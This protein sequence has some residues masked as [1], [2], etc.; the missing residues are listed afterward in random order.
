MLDFSGQ[1]LKKSLMRHRHSTDAHHVIITMFIPRTF[2]KPPVLRID[3]YLCQFQNL[4]S[5]VKLLLRS[6]RRKF[7]SLPSHHRI[8]SFVYYRRICVKGN[9]EPFADLIAELEEQQPDEYM[10]II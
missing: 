9:L 10:K 8:C 7:L 5:I 4:I 3:T 1:P 2:P 6:G